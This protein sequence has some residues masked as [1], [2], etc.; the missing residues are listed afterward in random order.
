MAQAASAQARQREELNGLYV[1]MSRARHGA[2]LY[3]TTRQAAE[4]A[5]HCFNDEWPEVPKEQKLPVQA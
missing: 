2:T 3:A 4:V 1:A 5:D